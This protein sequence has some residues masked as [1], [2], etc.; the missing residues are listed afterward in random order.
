M[1]VMVTGG[2][3]FIGSHLVDSLVNDGI[4][5]VS[6]D[7]YSA[8][9]H[10]NLS[11]AL[12][13]GLLQEVSGDV[14]DLVNLKLRMKG[15]DIVFHE[16]ASKKNICLNDPRKDLKVNAQGTFNV[17][18]AARDLGVKKIVH[19]STG[20]VYGNPVVLPQNETHPLNPVSY[21][22]VSKLAGDRY[23]MA[24]NKLYGMDVTVLRYFHVYGPRQDAGEFGGVVSIFARQILNGEPITIYGD[25]YQI[26]SFTY[27]KD[28][29]RINRMIA[30]M[31]S[32]ETKGE[33]Y[34]CA[35]GATVT[36]RQL[37]DY[38]M[39]LSGKKVPR[40]FELPLMGDIKKFLMD[41]SKI[42][43]LGFDFKTDFEAG[44]REVIDYEI[45]VSS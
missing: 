29:V 23:V 40:R 7:N 6:Y 20:S 12:Q 9:T 25:G 10:R 36:I 15:C 13:T 3:G 14:C 17:L 28:V 16:A 22:G 32:K 44:L 21:Y 2:A 5:V 4:E 24:F 34:N 11:S 26:R 45:S 37:A 42:R 30:G 38:L 18:E 1:K 33:V 35:S 43:S 27:V 41:T 31:V 8:G 19:A 39:A